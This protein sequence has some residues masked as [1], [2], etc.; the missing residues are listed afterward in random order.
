MTVYAIAVMCINQILVNANMVNVNVLIN[1]SVTSDV[2]GLANGIA[3]TGSSIGRA[4]SPTIMGSLFSWSLT[5]IKDIKGNRKPLGFPFN[6]YFSFFVA[7]KGPSIYYVTL[8]MGKIR[9]PPPVTLKT[10]D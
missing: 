4:C 7:G 2:Y 1:N 10:I 9:P 8:K 3:M 6:Q 5:N